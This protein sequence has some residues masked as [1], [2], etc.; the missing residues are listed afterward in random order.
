[1]SFKAEFSNLIRTSRLRSPI[2]VAAFLV[3]PLIASAQRQQILV[4]INNDYPPYE[5]ADSKGN[6]AGF[7]A[8]IVRAA[9]AATY[10]D[11]EVRTGKWS[12]VKRQLEMGRID[13]LAGML[14]SPERAKKFNF[15]VPYLAVEYSMFVRKG[16]DI[17]TVDDLAAKTAVVEDGSQ[18]HEQLKHMR[19]GR[20]LPV[21][22]EPEAIRRL[23]AGEGDVAFVPLLEGLM[24]VQDEHLT[25][26]K[27]AGESLF[28]RN[29]CFAGSYGNKQVIDRLNNGLEIIRSNGTYDK[30]YD[31]WFGRLTP[32]P[33]RRYIQGL[34]WVFGIILLLLVSGF[35]WVVTLKRR[36]R[37]KTNA[38]NAELVERERARSKLQTSEENYRNL[39]EMASDGIFVMDDVGVLVS[40]N[41]ALCDFLGYS[42]NELVGRAYQGFIEPADLVLQPIPFETMRS[43]DQL[44]RERTLVR[45]DGA[46]VFTEINGRKVGPG[47][48]QAMVRDIT[49][50]KNAEKELKRLNEELEDRVEARTTE[51]KSAYAE[52]ETFS[53]SVSHDLRGPLRAMCGYAGIIMEDYGDRLPAE[54]KAGLDRISAN[55]VKMAGLID[56]LLGYARMSHAPLTVGNVSL[57]TLAKDIWD[58]FVADHKCDHGVLKIGPMPM[59]Y[60]DPILLKLLLTNLL[61]NAR[62]FSRDQDAPLVEF[63]YDSVSDAYFVRDNGVGFNPEYDKKIFGVFERLHTTEFEGTGVGL[64]I[65]M[66]IAQRHNGR[67]WAEGQMG[68]GATFWFTLKMLEPSGVFAAS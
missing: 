59:A 13:L 38:L 45:K 35:A 68:S 17:S 31:K 60:G 63:G 5:F 37:Q 9:G 56:D 22:S 61:D 14:Y 48:Y 47:I 67:V 2:L 51:L 41:A 4:G 10:L 54:V 18:M 49:W 40:V 33:W 57:E 16:A 26:I 55:A 15:S 6:P 65:V 43:G 46:I 30:I 1:M 58:S 52:L 53:Y 7:D 24:L 3:A 20:I 32:M 25:G 27:P 29:L 62:K 19:V 21:S 8:D 39:F 34:M 28:P 36:V 50:R 12:D 42:R 44:I 64:A 11:V 66:R 23:A